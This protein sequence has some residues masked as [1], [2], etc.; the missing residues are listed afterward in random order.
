MQIVI[1]KIHLLWRFRNNNYN[2]KNIRDH[3]NVTISYFNPLMKSHFQL[4][5]RKLQEKRLRAR[6]WEEINLN[7]I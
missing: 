4:K 1:R 3:D 7:F 5:K 6:T 2:K